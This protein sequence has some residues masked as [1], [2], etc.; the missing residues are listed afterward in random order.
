L[1]GDIGFKLYDPAPC[2]VEDDNAPLG[3][4]VDIKGVWYWDRKAPY[5]NH[6]R[7]KAEIHVTLG[8]PF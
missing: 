7:D 2:L 3:S 4:P 8:L 5:S 1:R 6:F